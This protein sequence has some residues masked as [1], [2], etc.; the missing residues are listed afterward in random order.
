MSHTPA[1][2]LSKY[3]LFEAKNKLFAY[4]CDKA[5]SW[6]MDPRIECFLLSPSQSHD[7]GYG[8]CW[9]VMWEAGPYNWGI[10]L[11][12][13]SVT[14]VAEDGP[15]DPSKPEVVVGNP[16]DWYLEPHYSFDVGFIPNT[17]Y[18]EFDTEAADRAIVAV[19]GFVAVE[20][21][22][23]IARHPKILLRIERRQFENVIAELFAGFGYEVELTRQTRD[24]GKDIIAV[25]RVDSI[26]LRY[27]IE[28]KRPDPEHF[29]AVSTIREL[30]GVKADDPASKALL[31]TTTNF[32]SDA[33]ALLERHRWIL[34]GKIYDDVVAWVNNYNRLK[35]ID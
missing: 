26:E 27:L 33:R 4:V 14:F 6:G 9:R 34:E 28:C 15:W 19:S 12:G 23:E 5:E 31:V 18:A 16:S 32:T 1:L 24:G 8:H 21:M 3:D 20:L 30:L 17:P 11:S 29:V 35:G 22:K 7:L 2:D 25:K 10:E 13:G